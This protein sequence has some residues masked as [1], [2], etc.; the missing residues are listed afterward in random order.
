MALNSQYPMFTSGRTTTT[1]G[2]NNVLANAIPN[3]GQI[4][5]GVGANVAQQVNGLPSAGPVQRANAYFGVGS[6]MPGS[7]FIRNRGFD[8]YGQQAEQQKQRGFDNF[9]KLIS[10]YAG[11]IAPTVGQN[12]Q[13]AQFDAEMN[14]KRQQLANESSQG[15]RDQP[16]K[17]IPNGIY[18]IPG[19]TYGGVP[20]GANIPE[21]PGAF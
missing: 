3:F 5:T 21:Y 17:N 15:F 18:R 13:A 7:D 1:P 11:N 19:R 6:G 9:L 2:F 8:L 10:G 20:G 16:K 4:N 14:L 12:Q